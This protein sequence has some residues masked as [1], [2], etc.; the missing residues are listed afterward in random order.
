MI[1]RIAVFSITFFADTN[2]DQNDFQEIISH[3]MNSMGYNLHR[4]RPW[5]SYEKGNKFKH[6]FHED[7]IKKYFDN[8]GL[9]KYVLFVDDLNCFKNG[10]YN[11]SEFEKECQDIYCSLHSAI[12]SKFPGIDIIVYDIPQETSL[13]LD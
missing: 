7:A 9:F 12:V 1:S 5:G 8:R 13:Y 4:K 3:T 6:L 2:F 10:S 11:K